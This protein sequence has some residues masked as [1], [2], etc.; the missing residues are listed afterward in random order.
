M[1]LMPFI[2]FVFIVDVVIANVFPTF[3]SGWFAVPFMFMNLLAS[4]GSCI[5]LWD[6]GK[7][8]LRK[9]NRRKIV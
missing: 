2:I 5:V 6:S 8:I 4:V 7:S 3:A 9:H 1:W